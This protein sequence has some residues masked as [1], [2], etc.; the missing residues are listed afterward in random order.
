MFLDNNVSNSDMMSSPSSFIGMT[1]RVAP[2][3]SHNIC[4]G[5]IL[6][7]CSKAETIISSPFFKREEKPFATRLM[8]CVVPDVKM[9]SCENFALKCDCILRR[10]C[11]YKSVAS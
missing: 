2:V 6:L 5:T 3:R 10:A 4:Q 1:F 8:L 7:W 11:S 9:I